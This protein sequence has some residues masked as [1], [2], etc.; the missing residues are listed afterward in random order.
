MKMRVGCDRLSAMFG[1]F[2]AGVVLRNSGGV[3]CMASFW[4]G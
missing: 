2:G 3:V 4:I 1:G